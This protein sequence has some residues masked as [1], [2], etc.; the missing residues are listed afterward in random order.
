LGGHQGFGYNPWFGS[1]NGDVYVIKLDSDG[2]RV[3]EKTYGGSDYDEAYCIQQTSDGGYVVAGYTESFGAG[4]KDVYVI[5]FDASDDN[6]GNNG[7]VN[8]GD[9]GPNGKFCNQILYNSSYVKL[10]VGGVDFTVG[11]GCSECKRLPVGV[12]IPVEL[13]NDEG[14]LIDSCYINILDNSNDW[15]FA[16][17]VTP[18]QSHAYN[19]DL[20]SIKLDTGYS[21]EDINSY[22]DIWGIGHSEDMCADF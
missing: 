4:G 12:A 11:L 3:W 13:C 2:N 1:N 8:G 15:V 18:T 6:G 14:E 5:K 19:S 22:Q 20:M 21:C 9:L 10:N 7:G 17:N 16:N